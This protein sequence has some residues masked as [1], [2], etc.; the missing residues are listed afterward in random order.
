MIVSNVWKAMRIVLD[1]VAMFVVMLFTLT[2]CTPRLGMVFALLLALLV[3]LAPVLADPRYDRHLGERW[4]A[5]LSAASG[6]RRL[7]LRLGVLMGPSV[8]VFWIF[9]LDYDRFFEYLSRFPDGA[10]GA[11]IFL[12]TLLCYVLLKVLYG[13]VLIA[14]ERKQLVRLDGNP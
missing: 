1:G 14:Q 6:R 9:Y 3:M 11:N 5:L 2:F 7:M 8:L 4:N 10:H 12:L 13:I